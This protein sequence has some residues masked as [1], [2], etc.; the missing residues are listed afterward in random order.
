ML[1]KASKGGNS[2]LFAYFRFCAFARMSLYRLVILVLLVL[3]VILVLLVCVK[4]FRKKNN[5]KFNTALITSCILLLF[6]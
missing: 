3:L 6:F 5:E 2:H 4:S 1:L